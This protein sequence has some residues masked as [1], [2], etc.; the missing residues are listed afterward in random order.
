NGGGFDGAWSVYPFFPSGTVIVSDMNRGLFIL[1]VSATFTSL[2]FE[3]PKGRPEIVDPAGGTTMRV[4]VTGRNIDPRP[5]SGLLHY[6]SGAG[7]QVV[8]MTTVAPN[9]YDAVFP[10]A[11]CPQEVLYYVS[12]EAVGGEVY[13]DPAGAPANRYSAV[14]RYGETV[15]FEDN[16]EMNLGWTVENLGA[17]TG[18][19]QRGVPINDPA[20]PYD[21]IS[22][23]DGSGQCFVTQNELG[24]TDVDNGA[25]R[26]T[27]PV[28]ELSQGSII[29]YDYYLN[30]TN[31]AGVDRLLVEVSDD[32]GGS[33]TEIAN[34]GTSGGL[35]W[36]THSINEADLSAAGVALTATM[37][38]RY[39]ANDSDPQSIVEAGLDAFRITVDICDPPFPP[40]DLNCD[41]ALN[42]GD[43]DPFFL[44]L[45]DP[46]AYALAFPNCD[47]AL[48]DMNG[49]GRVNG[50]D[51]DPFFACL[52]GGV[53]P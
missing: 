41:G 28:F 25:V 31:P 47:A 5:D 12:A 24:N 38:M 43:I 23:S 16:F 50:G 45:G 11:A 22:D 51:I 27:S 21:P 26:L 42:G 40:G 34:H 4:V 35:S 37:R 39:T 2:N 20:W 14:A 1:D 32:G 17:S 3:Y 9:V 33:W 53:C 18:D 52:G 13:T 7:W 30:M 49:D 44:A 8:P 29:N 6:D 36:R 19:W 15:L 46:A 10:A 48:A